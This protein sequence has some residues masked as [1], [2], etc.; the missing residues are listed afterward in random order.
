MKMFKNEDVHLCMKNA[1]KEKNKCMNTYNN[2]QAC[3]EYRNMLF[4][5]CLSKVNEFKKNQK[6]SE[7]QPIQFL[8]IFT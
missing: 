5:D 6:N 7:L 3:R 4:R 2:E 8:S 1:E